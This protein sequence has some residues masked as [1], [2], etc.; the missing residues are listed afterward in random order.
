MH[1]QKQFKK[2][3]KSMSKPARLKE[4]KKTVRRIKRRISKFKEGKELLDFLRRHRV[5]VLI[6]RQ[7]SANA[8][9]Q[10]LLKRVEGNTPVWY[11][12]RI[13]INPNNAEC[14]EE[15]IH[16]LFHEIHHLKQYYTGVANP[17]FDSSYKDLCWFNRAMEADAD[18]FAVEM[19]WL[20]KLAGDDGPWKNLK[21]LDGSRLMARSFK[22]AIQERPKAL[23]RGYARR[24]AFDGWF[25]SEFNRNYYD[26]TLI[27]EEKILRKSVLEEFCECSK[28]CKDVCKDMGEI[29]PSKRSMKVRDIKKLGEISK[30]NYLNTHGKRLDHNDYRKRISNDNRRL[31]WPAS[32]KG[33]PRKKKGSGPK[34]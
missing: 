19:S 18:S 31:I 16:N 33:H 29:Y 12:G 23:K 8:E 5:P 22:K 13:L 2:N 1:I 20:M 9:F 26:K 28:V 10:C 27:E 6:D 32:K 17:P 15:M 11:K 25:S 21:A 24:A 34:R 14:D 3:K 4:D 30:V 7:I